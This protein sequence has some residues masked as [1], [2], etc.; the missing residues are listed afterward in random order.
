M[1]W[2]WDGHLTIRGHLPLASL[3]TWH[4]GR[5][6]QH[7][8]CQRAVSSPSSQ[9]QKSQVHVT[10]LLFTCRPNYP[11]KF[12]VGCRFWSMCAIETVLFIYLFTYLLTYLPTKVIM[13][14]VSLSVGWQ[15]KTKSSCFGK[16][17]RAGIGRH[18]EINNFWAQSATGRLSKF[19]M[20]NSNRGRHKHCKYY[21]NRKICMAATAFHSVYGLLL[22]VLLLL[23]QG[24]PKSD[25]PVLFLR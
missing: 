4:H 5:T 22:L 17:W 7:M 18:S 14:S 3:R 9:R 19:S 11:E 23:L 21:C 20:I 1:D 2:C 10:V 13:Y 25:N 15:T 16:T 6:L 24:G 8:R 12:V